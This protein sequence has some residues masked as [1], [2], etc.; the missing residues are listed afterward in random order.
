MRSGV[1]TRPIDSILTHTRDRLTQFVYHSGIIMKPV[2]LAA[3]AK[4][5]SEVVYCEGEDER[6]LRAVQIVV[7]EGLARPILIATT[8]CARRRE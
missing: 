6:V 4:S 3:K 8:A 7:D 5:T 2:F 1:A